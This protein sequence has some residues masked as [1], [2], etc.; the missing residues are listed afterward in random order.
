M[1]SLLPVLVGAIVTTL[2]QVAKKYGIKPRLMLA[3]LVVIIAIGYQ[4]VKM[5]MDPEMWKQTVSFV[6]QVFAVAVAIYEY[7][8]RTVLTSTEGGVS[9]PR[10][11]A[12]QTPVETTPP[13]CLERKANEHSQEGPWERESKKSL[14]P[15]TYNLQPDLRNKNLYAIE[16]DSQQRFDSLEDLKT[17]LKSNKDFKRRYKKVDK[18]PRLDRFEFY[19]IPGAGDGTLWVN[20]DG[21]DHLHRDVPMAVWEQVRKA[22]DFLGTYEKSV[23]DNSDYRVVLGEW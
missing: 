11:T 7:I 23:K 9:Q 4:V 16:N 3:I 22:K 17:Y 5:N 10:R 13:A 2:T 14:P 12:K 6:L 21:K 15:T 1:E 18:Y 20:L 19:Y 8:I